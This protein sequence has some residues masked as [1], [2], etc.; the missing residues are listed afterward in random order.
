MLPYFLTCPPTTHTVSYL[1]S[2]PLR[3]APQPRA[4]SYLSGPSFRP[5][6]CRPT[7]TDRE[8]QQAIQSPI[9]LILRCRVKRLATA[10]RHD[11]GPKTPS[12]SL[13]FLRSR[14]LRRD[15]SADW[16]CGATFL[17]CSR[18]TCLLQRPDFAPTLLRPALARPPYEPVATRLSSHW[19]AWA[20]L[21]AHHVV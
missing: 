2:F 17:T 6:S 1:F 4:P 3:A 15:P 18:H 10:R 7:T 19:T 9:V 8:G 11:L 12:S 16:L 21:R 20:F 14:Q 5:V 13:F